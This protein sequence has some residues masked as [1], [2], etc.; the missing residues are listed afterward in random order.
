MLTDSS[1][2]NWPSLLS[3][4][5]FTIAIMADVMIAASGTQ[6][7]SLADDLSEEGKKYIKYPK[8]FRTTLLAISQDAYHA[9][10]KAHRNMREI[11]VHAKTIPGNVEEIL[12]ILEEDAETIVECLPIPTK[13]IQRATKKSTE[14]IKEVVKEFDET[15]KFI[16]QVLLA[17]TQTQSS[18]EEK[19][20]QNEARKKILDKKE[21]AMKEDLEN[22]QQRISDLDKQIE[23]DQE[24]V[25]KAIDS[26]PSGWEMCFMNCL[27]MVASIVP[28]L[29]N[30]LSGN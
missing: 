18:T 14:L 15:E 21:A 19:Q 24:D 1:S 7:F 23:K 30:T 28:S 27:E 20:R 3:S 29:V 11:N 25:K 22:A 10:S 8:S 4:V 5:P 16:E 17:C 2:F 6:D 13:A 12:E 26:F 9:F